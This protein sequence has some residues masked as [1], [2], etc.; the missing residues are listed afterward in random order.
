MKMIK[1]IVN[2][3]KVIDEYDTVAVGLNG[4]LSDGIGIKTEAASALVNMK[5]QGKNI[6]L[7]S[8]SALRVELL[9]L[10]LK[11]KGF[12]LGVFSSIITA[13]EITHYKLKIKPGDFQAIG[14]SFFKIGPSTGLGVFA[15]LD[16]ERVNDL[17]RA[18]F[19]YVCGAENADDTLDK[20]LPFL[21]HAAGLNMPLLCV[22]NDTSTY[23][24]GHISLAAGALAE[25]FAVLGGKIITIGKPD[26]SIFKYAFDDVED[27][28]PD[29]TLMIGDNLT[30]D[31]KGANLSGIHAALVS[32]GVHVNFLG[33]GYIPD[34]AKTRELSTNFESYPDYVISNLRW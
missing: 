15:G 33:E 11:E 13:G 3:S 20:Y 8:N 5:K 25:Q 21:E 14:N 30:T 16:Y 34:V 19:L 29:R 24:E 27:F 22:G 18:D 17:A 2:I 32:K 7:I 28:N 6:I 31:I 10:E 12:P 1:P 26:P 4:V 23:T 9:A